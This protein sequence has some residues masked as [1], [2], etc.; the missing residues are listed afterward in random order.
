MGGALAAGLSRKSPRNLV[1]WLLGSW[2]GLGFIP[3]RS[4]LF[5]INFVYLF[6]ILGESAG[7]YGHRRPNSK[8]C[9]TVALG[10]LKTKI[11]GAECYVS[12][13]T[14]TIQSLEY[15]KDSEIES[16]SHGALGPERE[17][18]QRRLERQPEFGGQ[19]E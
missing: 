3:N 14:N 16:T 6:W 10:A 15:S 7:R 9:I 5:F 1:L 8:A 12:K 2:T 18:E 4:V 11:L 17:L 19:P 13:L